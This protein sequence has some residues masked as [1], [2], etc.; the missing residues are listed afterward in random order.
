MLEAN[1][2]RVRT[3]ER[4]VGG[5][6][7]AHAAPAPWHPPSCST[8]L[9]KVAGTPVHVTMKG[10]ELK[11]DFT[12]TGQPLPRVWLMGPV[13]TVFTGE[14]MVGYTIMSSAVIPLQNWT[15]RSLL[16]AL[17]SNDQCVSS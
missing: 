7:L 10:G 11:I 17:W 6:D 9:G 4:G 15:G 13:D 8:H 16:M 1:R 5:R 14:V 2:I 3:Y 12:R